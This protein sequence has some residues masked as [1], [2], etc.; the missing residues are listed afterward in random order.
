MSP[1]ALTALPIL[2]GCLFNNCRMTLS[3]WTWWDGVTLLLLWWGTRVLGCVLRSSSALES[4]L[5]GLESRALSTA[6]RQWAL[7]QILCCPCCL[8]RLT[9]DRRPFIMIQC[10]VE[11]LK[12]VTQSHWP[13][14]LTPA[15][16]AS[17]GTIIIHIFQTILRNGLTGW[18]TKFQ[19]P[20][21]VADCGFC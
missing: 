5:A 4:R 6:Q 16:T 2:T 7:I 21:C 9:V 18:G 11:Y 13:Y 12:F 19:P 8:A 17:H 1:T 3:V 20:K 15:S 14:Y 10:L